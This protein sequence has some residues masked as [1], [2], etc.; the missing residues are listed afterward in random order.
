METL[1]SVCACMKW[2]SE[3]YYQYPQQCSYKLSGQL[4]M[5]HLHVM[6]SMFPHPG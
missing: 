4:E 2:M 3:K 1:F 5:L 6:K